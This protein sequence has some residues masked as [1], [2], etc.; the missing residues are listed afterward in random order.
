MNGRALY[1]DGGT[2][3]IG[4]T[5][6]NIHG[7][8][9]AWQGQN[10]VAV[11]LR[12]HGE[13][14]LASTGEITNVTGTNAGNNCAIWTQFC[15]FTTKAGSKI[16]HVDGFQLLYFDDSTTTTTAMRCTSTVRSQNV[17]RVRRVF[18]GPGTAR[19]HLA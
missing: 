8:D 11:H 6:Q 1:A 7:T 4:G 14:T 13:A 10:G 12:S 5:I 9:A 16:S 2:A 15:N 17:L 18:C 3:N 19:S